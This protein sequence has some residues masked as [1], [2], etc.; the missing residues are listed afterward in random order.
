M[1]NRYS[2]LLELDDINEE[3][4]SLLKSK[5]VLI[6]GVGGVGQHVSLY[7]VTNGVT[8]LT[9]IDYDKV[10]I[11]NLNRQILLTESDIN[12]NKVE[13]VKE[14][15]LERNKEAFIKA[16]NVKV[17]SENVDELVKGYDL[18]MDATDNWESRLVISKTCKKRHIHL[19]HIGVDG[20][21]GQV[22]LFISKGLEDIVDD[23]VVS[24]PR[25]GVLGPMVGFVSSFGSLLAISYL[26]GETVK[27]DTLYSFDYHKPRIVEAEIK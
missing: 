3:K 16:L 22:C 4:L 26:L 1:M 10:E 14:A 24:S 5:R 2:R 12:K 18:V 7:L 8:N 6:I 17:T 21:K 27:K 15:L 23:S 20:Y 19:L 11:S 25:D 9:L 13:V